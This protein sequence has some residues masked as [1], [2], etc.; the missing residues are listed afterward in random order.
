MKELDAQMAGAYL[1]ILETYACRENIFREWMI[2]AVS[3]E[4]ELSPGE[5]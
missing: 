2:T 5:L 1:K 4:N 3:H